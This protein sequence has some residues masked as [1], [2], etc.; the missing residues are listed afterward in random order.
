[1]PKSTPKQTLNRLTF[2]V[3]VQWMGATLGLP[4]LPLFLEHRGGTP[5]IVGYIMAAFSIAG[6]A[7]QFL[8]GH[9]ADRHGRR[10][11]MIIGLVV[12]GVSSM[13]YLLP[14]NAPWFIITRVFQ[15]VSAGAIEVASMSAVSALFPEKERGRAI[16]RII[17]AQL[18]GMAFGPVAG[19]LVSVSALG[20]AF[21]ASGV[22][23]LLAA[24]Q[25]FR[26]NL[27]DKA[28]DPSPLPRLQWN[29]QL[30]GAFIAAAGTGFLIGVYET[31]WSL[32][33]KS[34][35]ATTLDIRLSWTFFCLPWVLLS[36]YGG[37]L[38]D[39]ANRRVVGT[40][41]L[42]NGAAF[43]ALYPHIHNPHMMV[44]LG[45]FES[46]GAALSVPSISSL[47]S[48]GSD[49]R[50][51]SRRQGLNATANTGALALSA[52]GS[53]YFFSINEVLPFTIGALISGAL[54]LSTIWW[55][56]NVQG[57]ISKK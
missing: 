34:H 13:T 31:C 40:V 17:A 7:S 24:T 41:G 46:I 16:S 6:L 35:H 32:L 9:Y 4:L 23:S 47:M 53:G 50:E 11:I 42:I 22:V 8:T 29:Q 33:M 21:F 25:T 52:V 45:A 37:W 51:M 18:G 26:T 10:P 38:A 48:E 36:K 30:I 39:H 27:G 56:R 2:I 15:G 43:L 57:N 12:Y 3:A 49:D 1:M 44:I 54:A 5:T 19:A 28:Y 55:W 20:W 14:V